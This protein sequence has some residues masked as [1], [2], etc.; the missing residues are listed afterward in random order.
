MELTTQPRSGFDWPESKKKK[1]PN[2]FDW[3]ESPRKPDEFDWPEIKPSGPE[4]EIKTF[5]WR[6][7]LNAAKE[8]RTIGS[9]AK[10]EE[11]E[12]LYKEKIEGFDQLV[13]EALSRGETVKNLSDEELFDYLEAREA[14]GFNYGRMMDGIGPAFTTVLDE[15]TRGMIVRG[16]IDLAGGFSK[17]LIEGF[18]ER[19]GKESPMNRELRMA[20]GN[21]QKGN[22][23]KATMRRHAR[24]PQTRGGD[25]PMGGTLEERAQ[26]YLLKAHMTNGQLM[27]ALMGKKVKDLSY[28][29]IPEWM[30]GGQRGEQVITEEKF[31]II[32]QSVGRA[33]WQE[34]RESVSPADRKIL[35]GLGYK[36]IFEGFESPKAISTTGQARVAAK[37]LANF[38]LRVLSSAG[39]G[40]AQAGHGTAM[41]GHMAMAN[42]KVG[43]LERLNQTIEGHL[44]D[45]ARIYRLKNNLPPLKEG[46]NALNGVPENEVAQWREELKPFIEKRRDAM[47]QNWWIKHQYMAEME[48]ARLGKEPLLS[49]TFREN[50]NTGAADALDELI[51]DDLAV[52]LGYVGDAP[53]ALAVGAA[54]QGLVKGTVKSVGGRGLASKGA[55]KT[56]GALKW[57]DEKALTPV[58]R[59]SQT[60]VGRLEGK[61]GPGMISR[62]VGAFEL[63]STPVSS[64]AS[65]TV[66]TAG[67]T[68]GSLGRATASGQTLQGTA[69]KVFNDPQTAPWLRYIAGKL[70]WADGYMAY[71]YNVLS[72]TGKGS[73]AGLATTLMTGDE[74]MIAGGIGSGG[75]AGFLFAVPASFGGVQR[76]IKA[77][78]TVDEWL[79]VKGDEITALEKSGQTEKAQTLK[80]NVHILNNLPMETQLR[81]A[82][83][84][85]L[86]KGFGGHAGKGDIPV[87]YVVDP[88][89]IYAGMWDQT[90]QKVVINL[91]KAERKNG[92]SMAHEV[93]HAL[94]HVDSDALQA[95]LANINAV[96]FGEGGIYS[97]ETQRD[98][99]NQYL[100]RLW[101]G[102]D[103]QKAE[104]SKMDPS[105]PAYGE[106]YAKYRQAKFDFDQHLKDMGLAADTR[107]VT[108]EGFEANVQW[109]A[110][111]HSE[112]RA[113]DFSSMYRSTNPGDL[114]QGPSLAANVK[115]KLMLAKGYS[116]LGKLNWFLGKL[117]IK[118]GEN[119]APSPLFMDKDG[120]PATSNPMVNELLK[121]Y[122]TLRKNIGEQTELLA[123][124]ENADVPSPSSEEMAASPLLMEMFKDAD[125]V[126]KDQYGDPLLTPDGRPVILTSKQVKKL[127]S[128]RIQAIDEALQQVDDSGGLVRQADERTGK[129]R[130]GGGKDGWTAPRMND[131]QMEA[132]MN[133]PD[134]VLPAHKKQQIKQFHDAM[135]EGKT[136][137]VFYRGITGA[138]AKR[139]GWR[140]DSPFGVEITLDGNINFRTINL[141]RLQDNVNRWTNERNRKTKLDLWD[142]DTHAFL[143][144]FATYREN[145]REGRPGHFGLDENDGK[146]MAKKDRLNNL[147]GVSG[148]ETMRA[149]SIEG[150]RRRGAE[151]TRSW[152]GILKLKEGDSDYTLNYQ[153]LR[154][155]L[156]PAAWHGSPHKFD[157]FSS[158]GIGTGEGAAAFGHGLYFAG[159]KEVAEFYRDTF[160]DEGRPLKWND[161]DVDSIWTDDVLDKFGEDIGELPPSDRDGM[162]IV[163]AEVSQVKTL[164]DA[165][166]LMEYHEQ[167]KLW[168]EY[169]D[170][171]VEQPVEK[172]HL[173]HV[174]LAPK[175]SELL[176]WDKPLSEQS[177]AVQK[178]LADFADTVESR[179]G[180][181]MYES[182]AF[183]DGAAKA[184]QNLLAEGVRGIKYLDGNSRS[185]GEGDFNFVIFDDR[186]VTVKARYM[187]AKE[188]GPY[189]NSLKETQYPRAYSGKITVPKL[190]KWYEENLVGKTVTTPD[191]IEITFTPEQFLRLVNKKVQGHRKGEVE[192]LNESQT[193]KGI[194]DGLI[195][196]KDLAGFNFV[197]AKNLYLIPDM[198]ENP[199]LIIHD[200]RDPRRVGYVKR[201]KR[202][203][204]GVTLNL[205]GEVEVISFHPKE[206]TET[207][208]SRY[209]VRRKGDPVPNQ[210]VDRDATGGP[211]S[212]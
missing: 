2:E 22:P 159:K 113:E 128:E 93:M 52:G 18:H 75:A 64:F 81:A 165:D 65:T 69:A 200:K 84:E 187:P 192:G 120:N 153:K 132:I 114:L 107:E 91:A 208:L 3:P 102:V 147:V 141:N 139:A 106:A 121:D 104:L 34:F 126:A 11:L 46:E 202:D 57:V 206:I 80:D 197:R 30:T 119:G 24:M 172:A 70:Q 129:V 59:F 201:Y 164:K 40:V 86:V 146:A 74:D 73:G 205:K 42:F 29:N 56:G 155:N 4:P 17:P 49:Q 195:G 101:S 127:Q 44:A 163:L 194:R 182:L 151:S 38:P 16:S 144:D 122:V 41:I 61:G 207:F 138:T 103:S 23:N 152:N 87:E 78:N 124:A 109:Q 6:D 116:T 204:V 92:A 90:N 185:K 66:R 82:E 105:D 190:F 19:L 137:A 130:W 1:K 15:L 89:A 179:S 112:I 96:M 20:L 134:N 83:L 160:E 21:I 189:I 142:G 171:F 174:D 99:G 193:I 161:K 167:S 131:A 186:D 125:E 36:S 10:P 8:G 175:D 149:E 7:R 43:G 48:R 170:Q 33:A 95:A 35:D 156:M 77:K 25:Q 14:A 58:N 196:H 67:E 209:F 94:E 180:K 98:R 53:V 60:V 68:L 157:Q 118:F 115:R 88:D 212:P 63:V 12:K 13:G 168:K 37:T 177:E 183:R 181:D 136:V 54:R 135:K 28:E 143:H 85:L 71:G 100:K 9:N 79:R 178:A 158:K 108:A 154:Q 191:G 166:R 211:Q 97:M 55:E 47:A 39:E 162:E 150:P 199:Q 173:Y 110:E 27:A 50:G 140:Q 51:V 123:K 5:T 31:D 203:F 72:S 198:L 76:Q 210:A 117:G 176:L 148:S 184:S 32:A 62:L 26:E 188:A 133:L 145:H 45:K 111:V 169:R